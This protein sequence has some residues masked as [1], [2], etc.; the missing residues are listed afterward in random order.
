MRGKPELIKLTDKTG[1][2][3]SPCWYVQW[4][5]G[6]RGRRCTTGCQI[7]KE[8][9]E[10]QIFLA[11]FI[12]E[13]ERPVT[14]NASE[15]MVA[16]ALDDY[17]EERGRYLTTAK[18][19]KRHVAV[20]KAHFGTCYVSDLTKA[21]VEKFIRERKAVGNGTINRE[22]AILSA[23]INHEVDENRL[24]A[25]PK[26]KKLP[27]PAPRTRWLTESEER[28]LLAKCATPHVKSFALLALNTG[29]R[30][31]AI[32]NL[33]WF[34]V[35][36]ANRMIYFTRGIEKKA[37]KGRADVWMNDTVYTLLKR[38]H[39]QKQTEYVLEYTPF[40]EEK[41]RHAGCVKKAFARA[42]KRAKLQGVSRYTMRHTVGATLRRK[43]A[44]IE[45]IAELLGH[46]DTKITDRHYAHHSP[47][48]IRKT[49][50]LL[51]KSGKGRK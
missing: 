19:A 21:R 44:S 15:L 40:G 45:H 7:G 34:Q 29:Q 48:T 38:L 51:R 14:R 4:Y 30:P 11:H 31:A 28:R 1:N 46:K 5:D 6:T 50:Q 42:V 12:I 32:E 10:A 33:T 8:D 3:K 37:N 27:A 39:K 17:Y 36:M 9:H 18:N 22:L 43:G 13:R 49:A 25:A 23:A 47:D 20:L 24:L 41:P 2:L 26:I 35:D 16:V